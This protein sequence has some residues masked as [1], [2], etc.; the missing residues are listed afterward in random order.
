[1]DDNELNLEI[2]SEI[3]GMSGIQIETAE[4]GKLAVDMV[5]GHPDGYYDIVFMDIRM[6]IMNGY[7]SASAIRA[8]DR[9]YTRHLPI[10]GLSANAFAEDV[11]MA[12]N[13]GMNAHISKPLDIDQLSATLKKW[14]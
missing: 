9:S 1:M 7:E 6:P 4:N 3:L 8:L 14:L 5:A 10:I 13:A 11:A 12:K 2:A